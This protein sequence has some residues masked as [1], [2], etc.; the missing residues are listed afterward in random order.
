M[1]GL[2]NND[3][4]MLIPMGIGALLMVIAH[5]WLVVRAFGVSTVWG[6]VTLLIPG[7]SILFFLF[8]FRCAIAPFLLGLFGAVLCGGP[9]VYS[10][11]NPP[12]IQDTIAVQQKTVTDQATGEK[13]VEEAVTLTGAKREEYAKLKTSK[14]WSVIQWANKD[15]TDKD[16]EMLH[17]ME[18]VRE[19]DLS[20]TDITDEALHVLEDMPK[21]AVLKLARTKITEAAFNEHIKPIESLME[22]DV[23]GTK[24][25]GKLIRDWKAAKEGRKAIN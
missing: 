4:Y 7:V 22:L 23:R 13:S 16:T 21:L 14:N 10:I 2:Q 3:L 19:L 6:L 17:G 8:H 1:P 20:D 18:N 24:I 15:V 25:P 11:I 5:L 12:K 9:V